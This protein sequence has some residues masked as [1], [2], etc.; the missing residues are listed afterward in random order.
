MWRK[1]K[2]TGASG[3]TVTGKAST[4]IAKLIG[5]MQNRFA[6]ALNKKTAKLTQRGKVIL[7]IVFCIVFGGGSVYIMID[8]LR[9]SNSS[10]QILKPGVVRVP[11]H[12]DKTGE[13]APSI[14][15]YITSDDMRR[16][17]RFRRFMD[18]LKSTRQ[19]LLIHDSIMKARPGLMDSLQEV[20]R[21][22]GVDSA[23]TK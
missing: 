9:S 11:K 4:G 7:L 22:Y 19:G 15:A 1:R 14:K 5:G 10:S 12:V 21:L 20:E 17:K 6:E 13:G 23:G 18:S 8:G 2:N 16:I 3:E